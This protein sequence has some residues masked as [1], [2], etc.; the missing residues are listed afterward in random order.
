MTLS[1]EK[2]S[3]RVTAVGGNLKRKNKVKQ[4]FLLTQI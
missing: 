4:I 3:S 2:M 1:H